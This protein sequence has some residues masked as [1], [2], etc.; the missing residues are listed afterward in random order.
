MTGLTIFSPLKTRCGFQRAIKAV[1]SGPMLST[2]SLKAAAKWSGLLWTESWLSVARQWAK[3]F[4]IRE[5]AA[6]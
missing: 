3:P 4:L 6:C 1:F 2:A 5:R